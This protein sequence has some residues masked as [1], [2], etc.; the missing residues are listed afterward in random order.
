[1]N[2]QVMN[3]QAPT[4]KYNVSLLFAN[5]T[6]CHAEAATREI[7]GGFLFFALSPRH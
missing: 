5:R 6:M 3:D 1:M 4:I 2:D 7:I